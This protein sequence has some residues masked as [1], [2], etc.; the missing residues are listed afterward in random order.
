MGET[1]IGIT[2]AIDLAQVMS[3]NQIFINLLCIVPIALLCLASTATAQQIPT[4]E[5]YR[6]LDRTVEQRLPPKELE[7]YRNIVREQRRLEESISNPIK[8]LTLREMFPKSE[9]IIDLQEQQRN[10]LR[11]YTRFERRYVP[12]TK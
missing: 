2:N 12:G 8:P 11:R 6:E 9:R 5:D 4:E 7:E 10:Y 1:V 3:R